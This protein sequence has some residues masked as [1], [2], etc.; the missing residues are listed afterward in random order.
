MRR[1]DQDVNA[2][3]FQFDEATR[4]TPAHEY[5][6][7]MVFQALGVGL[8][9]YIASFLIC[10]GIDWLSVKVAAIVGGF[11]ILII[12]AINYFMQWKMELLWAVEQIFGRDLNQDG[13]QGEPEAVDK[14]PWRIIVG[15]ED[16]SNELWLNFD[17][18]ELRAKAVTVALLV[19]NGTP[20]SENSLCGKNRPLSRSE[21]MALRDL[22]LFHGL[23]VWK[24]ERHRTLGT[25]FTAAGR[26]FI[27]G[28]CETSTTTP[29]MSTQVVQ[30]VLPADTDGEGDYYD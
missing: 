5:M 10:L 21:F 2:P 6:M 12:L 26:A 1:F 13:F 18:P 22:Y 7:H 19:E 14:A 28:T 8:A 27:R 16:T 30:K 15:N 20:F 24:D 29:R 25:K 3:G 23:I 17:T 9:A 11:V 4:K